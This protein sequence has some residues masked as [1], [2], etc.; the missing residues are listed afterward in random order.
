MRKLFL[1]FSL[2]SSFVLAF[3]VMACGGG[4]TTS[5]EEPVADSTDI[6][7]EQL[8]LPDTSYASVEAVKY[9]VENTDSL[10]HPL[11]DFNDRYEG[12]NVMAFR[13]NLMR[14]A[15]FGG[16]VTGT[17]RS[18]EIAWEFTTDYDTTHTKFGVWGGGSGWTGQPLYVKWTDEQ[19]DAFRQ[20]SPGLTQDF[21]REE[22]I[23]GSLCGKGYFINYETG[24]ASR[25]PLDL[26]N[27]VKGTVSLD[28][29]LYNLYVGQGVPRGAGPFGCQVFDLLKHQ[30][31]FFFGPDPKAWR[32]WNAFDSS[33]IVA[34]GFLFWPGENC[35]FCKYERRQGS[36]ERV[37]VMRYR[38]RGAAPGIE[39]SLC[40]YR[41]YGFFSDN[42]GNIVCVNLNTM[43]PVWHVRNLDDSDGT[44]VCR[45]EDGTPYLYTACEV[46]KQGA[47]GQCRFLKLNA[48]T[49][50]I[51]WE[52][53]IDCNRIDLGSKILDGGMYATPLLGQ[54]DC[55]GMIF[56]N[57]CRN[58]AHPDR[59]QLTAISTDDGRVLYAVGYGNFCWSSPVGFTNENN[60]FFV[61]TA[62][63]N[64]VVYVI[65][66]KNGEVLCKKEMGANFE[67]SP[68]VVGNSLVVGCRG[69]KIYKFRIKS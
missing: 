7:I 54:G 50:E 22:I 39:S 25:Q 31:T 34:G 62:D 59:G 51:V 29:E 63:A 15:S 44:I 4:R 53:L 66:G 56:A 2:V 11:K 9:V 6:P 35:S 40:V 58:S 57:I 27:V 17:P 10:P 13:K 28:P 64:G 61:F 38:V 36:L 12:D 47:H 26:G 37:S 19:L 41:N 16:K 67:S 5:N 52:S 8:M 43:R 18:I 45:V 33:P 3:A 49:G 65:R 48:L 14:N 46:D 23:V 24:K 69:T 55:E 42:H 32:S 21:G 68:C 1:T 60:E 20:S 30:R